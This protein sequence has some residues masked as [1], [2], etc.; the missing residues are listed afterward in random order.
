M[1]RAICPECS[2]RVG[3]GSWSATGECPSCGVSLMLT[4]EFRALRCAEDADERA[5][6]PAAAASR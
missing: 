6:E 4:C 5:S 3:L 2:Y 1:D